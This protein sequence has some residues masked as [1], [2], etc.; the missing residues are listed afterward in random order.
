MRI[1]DWERGMQT[2][3]PFVPACIVLIVL[4]V[5][6]VFFTYLKGSSMMQGGN[7][8]QDIIGMI[9]DAFRLIAWLLA[10]IIK[11]FGKTLGFFISLA[12]RE[13][14]SMDFGERVSRRNSEPENDDE[15]EDE[16]S[17]LPKRLKKKAKN[18][19]EYHV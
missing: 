10:G 11:V 15:D 12:R 13:P 14:P 18:V 5:A 16:A 1:F 3:G 9:I 6:L 19:D 7:V 8:V 2:I 4:G 17:P